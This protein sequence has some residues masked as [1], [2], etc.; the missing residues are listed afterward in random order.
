MLRRRHCGLVLDG[1]DSSS[2]CDGDDGA[3]GC[4]GDGSGNV[5]DVGD[6]SDDC[7]SDDYDDDN[8]HC[9]H[10]GDSDCGYVP[11]CSPRPLPQ[12]AGGKNGYGFQPSCRDSPTPCDVSG[13][14]SSLPFPVLPTHTNTNTRPPLCTIRPPTRQSSD[15]VDLPVQ[16]R[17]K[18]RIERT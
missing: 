3:S 14:A 6:C 2:A 11:Q 4:D 18:S 8:D 12:G 17:L 5:G 10:D 9:F 1:R 16:R 7:C 13:V 15:A